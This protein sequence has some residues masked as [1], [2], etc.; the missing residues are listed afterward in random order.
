MDIEYLIDKNEVIDKV[1]DIVIS[2]DKKDWNS[3]I[4]CFADEVLLDYT[5]L[6]GGEPSTLKP[7]KIVEAW[8]ELLPGFKITQ[9]SVTNHQVQIEGDEASC[10]SYINAVHYLPNDSGEDLWI[11]MGHF[12]HHLLKMENQWKVDKMKLIVTY[13]GGNKDLPELAR[14]NAS[15]M[16]DKL[17]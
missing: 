2:A 14:E 7:E 1:N 12:E 16:S 3:I 10:F 8:K 6:T 5:S 17:F 13:I 4:D 11:V 15:K 9:H